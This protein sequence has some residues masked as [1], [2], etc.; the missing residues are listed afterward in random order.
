MTSY[1]TRRI[2][3]AYIVGIAAG[4]LITVSAQPIDDRDVPVEIDVAACEPKQE[5]IFVAFGSTT[6]Q[7]VGPSQHGCV[8]LYGG[9]VENPSWDGLL[10]K[11]C[12][13]PMSLGRLAFAKTKTGVDFSTIEKY[14]TETPRP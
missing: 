3:A 13:V 9:E 12:V 14:C 4:P 1:R 8:L 2:A 10:N 11:T 5:R 7:I 6:Y